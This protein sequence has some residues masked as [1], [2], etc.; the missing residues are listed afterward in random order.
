MVPGSVAL[1]DRPPRLLDQVRRALRIRHYSPRTESAYAH[2]IVRY[3]RFHGIR[4]PN[5][6]GASEVSAFLTDLA[7]EGNDPQCP[8]TTQS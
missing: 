2:W 1:A 7:V 3:I 4:H 6:M 5:E 8:P